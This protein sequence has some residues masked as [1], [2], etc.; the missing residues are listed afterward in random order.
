M[1]YQLTQLGQYILG[2]I[3]AGAYL[4]LVDYYLDSEAE[5]CF[6]L[7]IFC[8]FIGFWGNKAKL[9][10]LRIPWNESSLKYINYFLVLIGVILMMYSVYVFLKCG[11]S[12]VC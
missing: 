5:I 4:L 10:I 3:F 2:L 12:F 9:V 11:F 8:T 1:K 7:G 6:A